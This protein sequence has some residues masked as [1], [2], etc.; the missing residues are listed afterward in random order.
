MSADSTTLISQVQE[1][2]RSWNKRTAGRQPLSNLNLFHLAL[3]V[4]RPNPHNAMQSV[5]R[6]GVIALQ[7]LFPDDAAL[8]ESRYRDGQPVSYVANRR[9]IAESTVF[10]QQRQAVD[11]LTEIIRQLEDEAIVAKVVQMGQRREVNLSDRVIGRSRATAEL[12]EIVG[13]AGEPWLIAIEGIGGIGKTTLVDAVVDQAIRLPTIRAVAWVSA[14]PA[15]LDLGG[16]IRHHRNPALSAETMVRELLQQVTPDQML[17]PDMDLKRFTGLLNASLR[18]APHLIVID[19]L[20]T[21]LDL[22]ELLPT[23]TTLANPSK[24]VVTTRRTVHTAVGMYHVPLAELDATAAYSLLRLEATQNNLSELAEYSDAQLAPIVRAVG[25]NPLA[26]RLVV[27]QL[28]TYDLTEVLHGLKEAR[29]DGIENLYSFIY[30]RAWESL[31]ETSRRVLLAMPLVQT[32]GETLD[33]I[34]F[35][36][37]LEADQL[38]AGIGTLVRHNLVNAMGSLTQRRY[39][40]HSLT[41]S[42]LQ[43]QVARWT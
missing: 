13:R 5:L 42:F 29:G 32:E 37:G 1:A 25:G 4:S 19:N 20:E 38:R 9:N 16:T 7:V 22:E 10:H 30:R 14:Q 27:G 15:M 40:I 17:T 8:L 28:H 43:E 39:G 33:F 23:L 34:Q 12:V 3:D 6:Q 24:I 21:V 31:D 11:R 41:R 35:V 2:L 26:L 18:K 36:S